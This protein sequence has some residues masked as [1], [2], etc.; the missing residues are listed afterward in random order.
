[1]LP[2][3]VH[4]ACARRPRGVRLYFPLVVRGGGHFVLLVVVV[5]SRALLLDSLPGAPAEG[6]IDY[7]GRDAYR[8]LALLHGLLPSPEPAPTLLPTGRGG[9]CPP[10]LPMR[11]CPRN[12]TRTTVPST[13]CTTRSFCITGLPTCPGRRTRPSWSF[14]ATRAPTTV[15]SVRPSAASMRSFRTMDPKPRIGCAESAAVHGS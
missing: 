13:P 11:A 2:P 15:P 14:C 1:M 12:P 5:G 8:S 6:R 10:P 3:E 7:I 9:G 4:D